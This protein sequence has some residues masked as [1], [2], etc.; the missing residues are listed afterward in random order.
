MKF[1]EPFHERAMMHF[2]QKHP[3]ASVQNIENMDTRHF[4]RK[5]LLTQKR[6]RVIF[7]LQAV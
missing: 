1:H 2:A 6:W 5:N 4:L 7:V 3:A